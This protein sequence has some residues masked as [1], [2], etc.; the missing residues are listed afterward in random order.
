M[1]GNFIRSLDRWIFESYPARPADLA[2]YRI[3][4]ALFLLFTRVPVAPWLAATPRAFFQPPLSLAAMFTEFP[5]ESRLTLL[6]V[7]LAL[8]ICLLLIGWYTRI[9]SVAVSVL[10]IVMNSWAYSLGKINHDILLTLSPL[11]LAFSGWGNAWSLDAVNAL[12]KK[13]VDIPEG[14]WC[15]TLLAL[16]IGI[17]MFTAGW[18]KASTGWLDPTVHA[19]YG[20]LVYNVHATGRETWAAGVF[21]GWTGSDSGWL[22][23]MA[24]WSAVL[25]E[26]GFVLAVF[27]RQ[28]F[29]F[30][31][32]CAAV[33][34]FA[35]WL[36][37]DIGFG[38]NLVC[39]A[40]FI[41]Y[42]AVIPFLKARAAQIVSRKTVVP[43]RV[44][45]VGTL[46]A[47]LT[48]ASLAIG[49]GEPLDS[50]L[51]APIYPVVL[52][53]GFV[54]GIGYLFIAAARAARSLCRVFG[55][56]GETSRKGQKN[57]EF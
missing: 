47:A 5:S 34:H 49:M 8:F 33:F 52:V 2:A 18:A 25:L 9:A 28:V 45:A 23:K 43:Q 48:A 24:D 14:S 26:L 30:F 44:L 53:V 38:A 40:A 3:L 50:L 1:T 55:F 37:F 4:L 7:V 29:Y 6:N 17:C 51:Q 19:T 15:L 54:V 42:A 39:Y 11:V 56:S 27:H 31:L 22:W 16:L 20:H 35:I 12:C 57:R 21:L 10:L 32:A 36:L 46:A 41:P 13:A